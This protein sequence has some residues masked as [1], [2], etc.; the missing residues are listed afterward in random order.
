MLVVYL[1]LSV[2]NVV[3]TLVYIISRLRVVSSCI[4]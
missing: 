4:A 2:S 3:F 1:V